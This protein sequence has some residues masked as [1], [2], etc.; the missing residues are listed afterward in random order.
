SQT[1]LFNKLK[2]LPHS[3]QPQGDPSL[4]SM[5]AIGNQPQTVAIMRWTGYVLLILMALELAIIVF[6]PQLT[7]PAWE[8]QTIGQIVERLPVPLIGFVLIFY[9]E[10]F[11][12]GRWEEMVLKALSW[13]T[14]AVGIGLLLFAPFTIITTGRLVDRATTQIDA[15]YTQQIDRVDR[16]EEQLNQATDTDIAN[17]LAQRGQTQEN[18]S[19]N[20]VRE[21]L[22]TQVATAREEIRTR[23]ETERQT[24]QLNLSKNSAK[25]SINALVT[26][27]LFIY[28]WRMTDWAR[29]GRRRR[30]FG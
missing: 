18:V 28:I 22:Q 3:T 29:R 5:P 30:A 7:D 4:Q 21:Q 24:Q 16:F 26:G 1:A 14:L 27:V 13:L 19:P 23:T 6:P 10:G 9:G 25:W 12:R 17:I 20:Q 11:L 8:F 2:F 15:A